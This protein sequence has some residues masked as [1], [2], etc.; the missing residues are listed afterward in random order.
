MFAWG[1]PEG[2]AYGEDAAAE[3]ELGAWIGLTA[4]LGAQLLRIV[5]AGPRLRPR[6]STRARVEGTARAFS[7]AAA[8]AADV[9][10]RLAVENHAD[11]TADE[12]AEVVERVDS[13]ALG[14]C[15]DTA[16]ALRVGDE[17]TTAAERLAPWIVMV[18]LKDCAGDPDR[19]QGPASVPYGTGVVPI[20]DV[21][22]VV[23]EAQPDVAVC[24]ELAQLDDPAA[25]EVAWVER[26]VAWLRA[27]A[28]RLRP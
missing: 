6:T 27:A 1:H 4:A 5:A 22:R 26:D 28:A 14:V 21:L 19:L 23:V 9:G 2:V 24:V 16:N 17:P 3:E 13:P 20:E 25:D 15:L 7:T 8:R 12:L 18:H 10:V 11:L